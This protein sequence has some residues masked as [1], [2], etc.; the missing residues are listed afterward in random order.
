LADFDLGHHLLLFYFPL[1]GQ[2]LFLFESFQLFLF[3]DIVKSYFDVFIP[4]RFLAQYRRKHCTGYL[5]AGDAANTWIINHGIAAV[6]V[7]RDAPLR[8][9]LHLPYL[10][11]DS[12]VSV[13]GTIL[14]ESQTILELLD[15]VELWL[16]AFVSAF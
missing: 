2:Y 5:A 12:F 1:F 6:A 15:Q 8:L 3:Y 13:Q 9:Q 10:V 16:T 14:E 11:E 7:V 4:L